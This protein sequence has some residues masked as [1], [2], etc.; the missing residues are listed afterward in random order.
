MNDEY[1]VSAAAAP[2]AMAM[3][4][5]LDLQMSAIAIS[6]GNVTKNTELNLTR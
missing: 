5:R 4:V 1:I 3:S 6:A 2:T